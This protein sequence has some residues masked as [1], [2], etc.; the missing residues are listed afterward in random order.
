[1][2][3]YRT[4]GQAELDLIKES[5]W[6]K[7]PT[8]LFWQPILYIVTTEEYAIQIARDWNATDTFS[9]NVGYVLELQVDDTFL[10]KYEQKQV[11]DKTHTEYWI[12]SEDVDAFNG[13]I[14]GEIKLIHSF[15]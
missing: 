8:R 3:V 6:R 14:Q 2:R 1:M 11:G 13:A 5:G 9:S 12:P 10:A 15:P 4:T 7:L